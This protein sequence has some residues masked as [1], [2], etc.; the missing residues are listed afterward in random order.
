M[1][2]SPTKGNPKPPPT[3]KPASKTSPAKSIKTNQA[4]GSAS[5]NVSPDKDDAPLEAKSFTTFSENCEV[6]TENYVEGEETSQAKSVEGID[7]V[8]D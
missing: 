6:V 2:K 7:L 3:V 8:I 1:K 4:T 5:S